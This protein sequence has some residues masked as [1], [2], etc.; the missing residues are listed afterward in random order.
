MNNAGGLSIRPYAGDVLDCFVVP[1]R[2]DEDVGDDG[3]S[4]CVQWNECF[5]DSG[6]FVFLKD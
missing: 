6:F 3:L 1:P 2:N 5:G 4:E